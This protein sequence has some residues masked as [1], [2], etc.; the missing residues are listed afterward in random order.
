[1]ATLKDGR[2][3]FIHA[4]SHH[5]LLERPSAI[6]DDAATRATS[7]TP[8]ATQL[9]YGGVVYAFALNKAQT[10]IAMVCPS[11]SA[12]ASATPNPERLDAPQAVLRLFSFSNGE[13]G[14]LLTE[15]ITAMAQRVAWVG[16]RYLA[17]D[18]PP[19]K[20][21]STPF[22]SPANSKTTPSNTSS[23][24]LVEVGKAPVRLRVIREDT[25]SASPAAGPGFI[26]CDI[27]TTRRSLRL[28]DLQRNKMMSEC[29]LP[30]R[31]C[32]HGKA[33]VAVATSSDGPF[34]F[35]VNDDWTVHGFYVGR[36]G[37]V[38]T[39]RPVLTQFE[40]QT[41][42]RALQ[43]N[44]SAAAINKV[45][46]RGDEGADRS[47]REE[48]NVPD[49]T[50]RSP[51]SSSTHGVA[52]PAPKLHTRMLSETQVLLALT[53]SSTVLQCTY[54]PKGK[55]EELKVVAK[56]R[57][58]RR[59]HATAEVVGLSKK[60]CLVCQRD[61]AANNDD[62]DDEP[63][64]SVCTYFALPLEM[65]PTG[66][67]AAEAVVAVTES[68][69]E[70]T[71][72]GG[73]GCSGGVAVGEGSA[74]AATTEQKRKRKRNKK[75]A[76][77]SDAESDGAATLPPSTAAAAAANEAAAGASSP[78][79]GRGGTGGPTQRAVER[80]LVH[81]GISEKIQLPNAFTRDGGSSGAREG[82]STPAVPTD[83]ANGGGTN[84][85]SPNNKKRL[86]TD[87]LYTAGGVVVGAVVMMCVMR[88]LAL[89]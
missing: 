76:A 74:A 52:L 38:H 62:D 79:A 49:R 41:V 25:T 81:A 26:L 78:P 27:C 82:R 18:V 12:A 44:T 10:R 57:L 9:L 22:T 85:P 71:E 51:R 33:R 1:M 23:T 43:G 42:N 13:V 4:D 21:R 58:T 65:K 24:I 5:L 8:L 68:T 64:K 75:A 20:D 31:R 54:N 6:S 2:F 63:A 3:V 17:L 69:E 53:G 15:L 35:V 66:Q 14:E 48:E 39:P 87:A 7:S 50:G 72:S 45:E 40:S 11:V 55:D 84:S 83:A 86:S 80:L 19:D 89:L 61:A 67:A 28:W 37:T 59:F 34:V 56:M 47:E 73:V 70:G 88:K 29:Q 36:S 46:G 30:N 77:A 60:A 16:D 32:R